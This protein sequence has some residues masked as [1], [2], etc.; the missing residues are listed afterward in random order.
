MYQNWASDPEVT[1]Y[2]TWPVHADVEVSKTV[3]ANWVSSY[4]KDDYYHWAI[5]LKG[6]E[7]IRSEVLPQCDWM[8]KS[9]WFISAIALEKNGGI[10][11][12]CPRR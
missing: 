6:M 1:K 5:V 12:S 7:V 10:G 2:L 4:A 11:V 3:L 9:I 8:K